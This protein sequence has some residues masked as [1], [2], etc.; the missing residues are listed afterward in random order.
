MYPNLN[1]IIEMSIGIGDRDRDKN[2]PRNDIND[3]NVIVLEVG[4]DGDKEKGKC[5]NKYAVI[6]MHMKIEY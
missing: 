6:I 1:E 2:D 4:I 5:K 3:D